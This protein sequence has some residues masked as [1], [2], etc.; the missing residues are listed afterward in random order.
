MNYTNNVKLFRYSR[1]EIVVGAVI[2][3]ILMFGAFVG[4]LLTSLIFWRKPQLRTPTNISILFLSITDVLMASLVMPFS[5]ASLVEEKWFFSSG[6]CTFNAFLLI[7]LLGA[8]LLTMTW[9][10][11][12]RYL[13]VVKP[14]LHHQYV[15]PKSVSIGLSLTWLGALI[16][17]TLAISVS[18]AN[19][20][21]DYRRTFC[22]FEYHL[23]AVVETIN[24]GY[25][26]GALS[27]GLIIFKAYFKVFRFVSHHNNAVSSNLNEAST[28]RTEAKITKTLVF[29][30]LGFVSLWVPVILIQLVDSILF[31]QFN[32]FRMPNF[33]FLVQTICIFSIS[34]I[35]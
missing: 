5:L 18:S 11:V 1:T 24:F 15:K 19:G 25:V 13:C 27:L 12:I 7:V 30:V 22:T 33:V 23:K 34:F 31:S 9:T 14:A 35:N 21:Y 26:A 29:V 20:V 6:A 4:N 8:S 3:V 28:L 16:L 17:Q 10:A 32:Q 2:L